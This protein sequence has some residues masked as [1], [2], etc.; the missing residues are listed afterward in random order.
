[1][2]R[3]PDRGHRDVDDRDVGQATFV[4]RLPN[5][6]FVRAQWP[7]P[8]GAAGRVVVTFRSRVCLIV[9]SRPV[10]SRAC[11]HVTR[12][13]TKWDETMRRSRNVNVIVYV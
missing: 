1:V 4:A 9:P 11:L 3:P 13:E 5:C 6:G 8:R 2:Q 12:E 10:P 7:A